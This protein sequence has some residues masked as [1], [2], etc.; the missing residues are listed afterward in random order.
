MP[1][2]RTGAESYKPNSSDESDSDEEMTNPQKPSYNIPHLTKF[3]GRH[4]EDPDRFFLVFEHLASIQGWDET[5]MKEILPLYLQEIALDYVF[6]LKALDQYDN[7]KFSDLKEKLVN[8]GRP[9]VPA[10][11]AEL[12]IHQVKQEQDEPI[13]SYFIRKLR[14]I[15]Q[16]KPTASEEQK[17]HFLSLGLHKNLM[18]EIATDSYKTVDELQTK[19]AK[20]EAAQDLMKKREFLE[21]SHAINT[22]YG[23]NTNIP[24]LPHNQP[25]LPLPYQVNPYVVQPTPFHNYEPNQ[26]KLDI[27]NHGNPIPK[28][29]E[30]KPDISKASKVEEK[31]S[32][33]NY[34]QLLTQMT[35]L[36]LLV[37]NNM[38]EQQNRRSNNNNNY[39]HNNKKSNYYKNNNG[40]QPEQ[41]SVCS[42]CKKPNHKYSEC[43]K[44]KA[45]QGN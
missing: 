39:K 27:P 43:R 19:L 14:V 5:K 7:L 36:T 1:V 30:I 3:S 38:A 32:Q 11:R 15:R 40:E 37:A 9:R 20:V 42:F 24:L 25:L 45:N 28:E 34:S 12:D 29:P 13:H 22:L 2:T 4:T 31:P 33:D 18:R 10:Y 16:N 17:V 44:R 8:I 41:I 21:R 35:N 23:S 26:P 6:Q